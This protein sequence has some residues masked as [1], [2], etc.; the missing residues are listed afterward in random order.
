MSCFNGQIKSTRN[1][2]ALLSITVLIIGSCNIRYEEIDHTPAS[3]NSYTRTYLS[4]DVVTAGNAREVGLLSSELLKGSIG[5]MRYD[6]INN[7]L[8]VAEAE[9]GMIIE[10][11]IETGE[12]LRHV[13]LD[14]STALDLDSTGELILGANRHALKEDMYGTLRTFY[15]GIGVWK[16]EEA[17]LI[18]CITRLC[19][20]SNEGEEINID[21]E[22]LGADMDDK[23]IWILSFTQGTFSLDDLEG[24]ISPV[25]TIISN[26]DRWRTMANAVLSPSGLRYAVGYQQGEV[27]VAGFNT[28]LSR[29]P[30]T[31]D[32]VFG[33]Y[34]EG[35]RQ[36]VPF[37]A[38]S[39]QE[40][41][42]A[43]I[44]EDQVLVWDIT[45]EK[46]LFDI[47][48]ERGRAI[49]FDPQ[50]ELL[51]VANDRIVQVWDLTARRVVVELPTPG[52]TSVL[53]SGDG[54]LLIW[55]D[56]VGIVHI[57]AVPNPSGNN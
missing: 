15:A 25:T 31:Y 38:F 41:L 29:W 17:E 54:R 37:I 10:W 27:N 50:D 47:R 13:D 52:L 5:P 32:Y 11:D 33:E 4:L 40:E 23:G 7:K 39:N 49:T 22:W 19:E 43:I 18:R 21:I 3:S 12:T 30:R 46:L 8:V 26:P 6:S 28:A 48:I 56:E 1:L 24:N 20:A 35:A 57:W 55:G 9:G 45:A 16:W 2:I 14:I 44:I 51:M 34:R 53:M 42:L 36:S